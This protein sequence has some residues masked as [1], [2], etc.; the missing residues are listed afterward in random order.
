MFLLSRRR[1]MSALASV[2]LAGGLRIRFMAV[3][4]EYDEARNIDIVNPRQQRAP[5]HQTA[6]YGQR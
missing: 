1:F 2:M 4:G 5:S 6:P 3:V